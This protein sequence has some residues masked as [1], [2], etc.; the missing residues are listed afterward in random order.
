MKA[1]SFS[2]VWIV[3]ACLLTATSEAG[4][5][6]LAATSTQPPKKSQFNS[7][8]YENDKSESSFSARVKIVREV[9]G[10]TQVFFEGVKGFYVLTMSSSNAGSWQNL[11]TASQT[12]KFKVQVSVDPDSRQILN[13]VRGE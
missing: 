6:A 13:V 7:Q 12:K 2:L 4:P 3:G 10:D 1:I 8:I 11:L 9:Q 5:T